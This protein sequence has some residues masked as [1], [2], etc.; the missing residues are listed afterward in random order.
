M[1]AVVA[2]RRKRITTSFV[3]LAYKPAAAIQIDWGETT[4]VLKGVKTKINIW[5][6][7]EC[8]SADI[9]VMAFMRQN[10]ESFLEGILNG[11]EHFGGVPKK[12]IFD[13][14]KVAVKDGF[15]ANAVATDKYK[16]MAAHYAFTPVFCNV[17]QGHEKG[18]VE[19]PV[20]FSRRNFLVPL[21][22]FESL[23]ELNKYLREKCLGYQKTKIPGKPMSVGEMAKM[24]LQSYIPLPAYRFD[25][26]KT[27]EHKADSFSLV[28]FDGNKYSVPYQYSNKTVTVK[29]Y[30]DRVVFVFRGKIIAEY[31]RDYRHDETN[32]RLKH[33][34]DL[35]ERKPRSVYDA[36]PV[37]Q[38]LPKPFYEFIL[39]LK[40]P[41]EVV[42]IIRCYLNNPDAA[43][44]AISAA[45]YEGFMLK[46]DLLIIDELSYLTFNQSRSELLFQVISERSE[47][48]SVIITTN[49]E[50]SQWTQLF[51]N[52][53][54]VAA[55]VDRVTF[56]SQILNMNCTTSYRMETALNARQPRRS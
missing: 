29:G 47:R 30:G 35:I 7:R 28:K 56:N 31:D 14:A 26:S 25:T 15:G 40:N 48:A 1:R 22:R 6:M 12:L 34:I 32:F 2:E 19:G 39:T 42:R 23:D 33:Y 37:K 9:F 24:A 18:L 4:V 11:F 46:F 54:M 41:K 20:G 45:N 21:P 51:E 8:F 13:N 43:M 52:E 16:A 49:L 5:C 27:V 17:A 10:E 53:M 38:T 36:A 3:P 44:S 50:F 55:L